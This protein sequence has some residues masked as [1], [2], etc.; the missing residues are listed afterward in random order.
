MGWRDKA[1]SLVESTKLAGKRGG[2]A[3]K[4]GAA[5]AA[6][7]VGARAPEAWKS[8][9]AGASTAKTH[10][11]R[12]LTLSWDWMSDSTSDG[13]SW[14]KRNAPV[15]LAHVSSGASHVKGA[16]QEHSDEIGAAAALIVRKSAQGLQAVSEHDDEIMAALAV[17]GVFQPQLLVA[18]G[19]YEAIKPGIKVLTKIMDR[20]AE[21]HSKEKLGE[22]DWNEVLKLAKWWKGRS[23]MSDP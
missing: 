3:A 15:A 7:Y 13:A 12:G 4:R 11:R 19:A 14:M 5:S 8:T 22:Q 20:R 18:A 1:K 21:R 23:T 17:L 9:R 6:G 2:G 16:W 10:I